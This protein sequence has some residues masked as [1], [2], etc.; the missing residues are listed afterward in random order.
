MLRFTPGTREP[1][2]FGGAVL[3]SIVGLVLL[4]ACSNVANLLMARAAGRQQEVAVRLAL[5]ASRG[6]LIRQL[7]TESVVLALASGIAGL[8]IAREGIVLLNSFRPA[9][10]ANNLAQ[11]QLD[12]TVFVFALLISVVTGLIFGIVPAMQSTRPD[13]AETLKQETRNTGRS[14]RRIS[15]GNTLLVGQV[16]FSLVAL[17]TAG[18]CLRSIQHAY[19]IDPGFETKKLALIL[20]NPGQAGYNQAR[21]EQFYREARE[22]ASQVPGVVSISWASNLPFW[23][24]PTRS[25]NDRRRRAA[26]QSESGDDHRQHGGSRLFFN[27]RHRHDGRP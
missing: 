24:R 14:R 12:P 22:R 23:A 10:V 6:R 17:I 18:L 20:T 7:L 27:S 13:I 1:A 5:G 26:R 19:T 21:S 9:Q 4:I 11:A 25:L 16:A 2:I 3:M 8:V 15:F